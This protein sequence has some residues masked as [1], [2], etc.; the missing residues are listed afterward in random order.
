MEIF[1]RINKQSKRVTHNCHRIDAKKPVKYGTN[2]TTH[3]KTLKW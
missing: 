3:T 1:M 2:Q